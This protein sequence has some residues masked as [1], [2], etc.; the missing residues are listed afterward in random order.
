MIYRTDSNNSKLD[1]EALFE[2]TKI[3]LTPIKATKSQQRKHKCDMILSP[4]RKSARLM[5]N[6]SIQDIVGD[7]LIETTYAYTNNKCIVNKQI[8][9]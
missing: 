6:N 4:V 7:K 2:S 1:K 5:K 3:I 8:D 9:S